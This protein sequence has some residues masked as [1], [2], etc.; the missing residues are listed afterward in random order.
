MP[1][2]KSRLVVFVH[3]WSV[4]NTDTY[5]EFPARLQWEA[6]REDH[7]GDDHVHEVHRAEGLALNVSNAKEEA[8]A[9]R[10]ASRRGLR[11]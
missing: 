3:G 9:G 10:R 2:T 5:G 1:A 6:Q 8:D 7:R 4:S 11:Q